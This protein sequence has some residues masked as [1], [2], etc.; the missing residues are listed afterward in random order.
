MTKKKKIINKLQKK[1]RQRKHKSNK[2]VRIEFRFAY[3]ALY[4]SNKKE[5]NRN[6]R[7][8]HQ[9]HYRLRD[10]PTFSL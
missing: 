7:K 2:W 5:K 6:T 8:L 1:K 9:V 4:D 10:R 3:G